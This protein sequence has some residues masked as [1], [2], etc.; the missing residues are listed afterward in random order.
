MNIYWFLCARGSLLFDSLVG[1]LILILLTSDIGS[2]S[3]PVGS[4]NPFFSA[5]LG[6]FLIG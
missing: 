1:W 5:L 6:S 4:I 3:E 2:L